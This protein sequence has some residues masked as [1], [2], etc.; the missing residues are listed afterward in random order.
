[1][2]PKELKST[3]LIKEESDYYRRQPRV[4]VD[5]LSYNFEQFKRYTKTLKEAKEKDDFESQRFYKMLAYVKENRNVRGNA[6]VEKF[7]N[8]DGLVP[9]L[10]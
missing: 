3:D 10:I 7:V 6:V 2:T 9:E 5:N 4:D 8:Q 1:M